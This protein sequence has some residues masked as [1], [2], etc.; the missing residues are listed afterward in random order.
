[1]KLSGPTYFSPLIRTINENLRKVILS[2]QSLNY[3]ILM[4]ITDGMICDMDSTIDEIVESAKLPMS[5]II[6]GLGNANFTNMNILDG[7]DIPLKSSKNEIVERD[8]VQFVPFN[9]FEGNFTKLTEE[10]LQ[11]IPRQVEEYYKA[12]NLKS[13]LFRESMIR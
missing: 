3:M 10:V 1:M 6:I 9:K 8:I 5:I 11:E 13:D 2:G 4:I 12:H 7:D